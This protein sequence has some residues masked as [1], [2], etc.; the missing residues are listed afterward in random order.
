MLE[1]T[2]ALPATPSAR[3]PS[4]CTSKFNVR[5]NLGRSGWREK[6][7]RVRMQET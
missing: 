7:W 2:S 5:N 6:Q 4:P 1:N 3:I